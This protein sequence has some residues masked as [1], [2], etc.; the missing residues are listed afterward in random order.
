MDVHALGGSWD[1]LS[2]CSLGGSSDGAFDGALAGHRFV[3]VFV[4]L[5]GETV[6]GRLADWWVVW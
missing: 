3:C 6:F 1:G 5:V 4:W 2:D